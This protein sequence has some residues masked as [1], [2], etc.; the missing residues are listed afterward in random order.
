MTL[1]MLL[2]D[3]EFHRAGCITLSQV[4][5][6]ELLLE[7]SAG[8]PLVPSKP[9]FPKFPHLG[10]MC[11]VHEPENMHFWFQLSKLCYVLAELL[12]LAPAAGLCTRDGLAWLVHVFKLLW[13]RLILQNEDFCHG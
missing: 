12:T 8:I 9:H 7:T 6:M 2:L 5:T 4:S 3:S 1:V 10:F 11:L 13:A